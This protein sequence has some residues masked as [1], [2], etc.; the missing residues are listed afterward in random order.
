MAMP[1]PVAMPKKVVLSHKPHQKPEA[2]PMDVIIS[3]DDGVKWEYPGNWVV[4]FEKESPF[5]SFNFFPG[6]DTSGTP[7]SDAKHNHPYKYSVCIEG[8]QL[9]PNVI[10]R[11]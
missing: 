2:N 11:P 1:K 7:K 4:V 10:I 9:D 5:H 3:M 8:D 6:N